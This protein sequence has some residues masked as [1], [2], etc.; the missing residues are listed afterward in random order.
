MVSLMINIPVHEEEGWTV[1]S[2]ESP[3]GLIARLAAKEGKKSPEQR[4]K[5]EEY[6]SLLHQAHVD[7]VAA[8]ARRE[9]ERAAEA[10]SRRLRNEA[11]AKQR[12]QQRLDAAA[13][14]QVRLEKE[15]SQK[16]QEKA[17][18]RNMLVAA[19]KD[20]RA[21][22][23]EAVFQRYETKL[24]R[25]ASATST[26]ETRLKEIIERNAFVVKRALAVATANKEQDKM[27][28]AA[29]AESIN[30]RM[31]AAADRR[32]SEQPTSPRTQ[33]RLRALRGNLAKQA[34]EL[35]CKRR[36]L[37]KAQE[38]AYEK[39][40]ATLASVRQ[41]AAEMNAKVTAAADLRES[42]K[43][44]ATGARRNLFQKLNSAAVER[45]RQR[46]PSAKWLD[47]DSVIEIEVHSMP[48][49]PPPAAL[50]ERLGRKPARKVSKGRHAAAAKK[51]QAALALSKKFAV[52]D[53]KRVKEAAAKRKAH[54]SERATKLKEL[55][56]S[57]MASVAL[58]RRARTASAK[59]MN[60][61]VVEAAL[62]RTA[63]DK[64][65]KCAAERANLKR[66]IAA[67]RRAQR[68]LTLGHAQIKRSESAA[69]RRT[70]NDLAVALRGK[71]VAS[72]REK[73]AL[74]RAEI[75]RAR[76]VAAHVEKRTKV[77]QAKPEVKSDVKSDQKSDQKVNQ[78]GDEESW[79]TV[80]IIK[81]AKSADGNSPNDVQMKITDMGI[82]PMF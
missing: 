46:R 69:H 5:M 68:L 77:Q 4:Q 54:T 38:S 8:R 62:R 31:A 25:V 3:M 26:R 33:E 1:S 71:V 9:N 61:R 63:A 41:R 47:V 59:K 42:Q 55:Q 21:A 70:A 43:A 45:T 74:R 75:L 14:R 56:V 50:V 30:L 17:A 73:A 58:A 51:Q 39:R 76:V 35:G 10:R 6:S 44:S 67:G 16:E 2:P 81:N 66:S 52:R 82:I 48:L 15:K 13:E 57:R 23:R 24:G 65:R 60:A 20:A 22:Q 11:N 72:A 29:K 49:P 78:S 53:L 19:V 18:Q 27:T 40:E 7:A 28:S 12:L 32:E 79:V 37:E 36:T 64:A 80:D 34:V